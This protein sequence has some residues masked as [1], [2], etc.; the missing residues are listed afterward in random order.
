[1]SGNIVW[2]ASYPKSG[3]TWVR[4]FIANLLGNDDRPVHI[5]TLPADNANTRLLFDAMTGVDSA[6]LLAG[7][8]D[9]LRPGFYQA[10]AAAGGER[11]CYYK[12]HDAYRRLPDGR[13][14]FPA[15]VTRRTLYIVR[16][17]LAVA[18][19]FARFLCRDLDCVIAE[20]DDDGHALNREDRNITRMLPQLLFSWSGHVRSWLDAPGMNVHLMRYED[21]LREPEHTFGQAARALGFEGSTAEILRAVEHASFARLQEMELADGFRERPPLAAAFFREGTA[22]GWRD[23]LSGAQVVAIVASHGGMMRRLGYL[24]ADGNITAP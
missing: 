7:E 14:I 13:P 15:T 3:N 22:N 17:P 1:M 10:L 18:P 6:N 16:N 20:M 2:I 12:I 11:P 5:N 23:V 9:E 24:D 21:M 19:S 4:A 8:I